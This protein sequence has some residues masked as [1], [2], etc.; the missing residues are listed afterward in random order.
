MQSE[1]EYRDPAPPRRRKKRPPEEDLLDRCKR[2]E[3]MLR[4]YGAN[5]DS[6][7]VGDDESQVRRPSQSG[8][9]G[10]GRNDQDDESNHESNQA[11]ERSE[12]PKGRI[13]VSQGKSRYVESHLWNTF[14][15]A[16]RNP[17]EILVDSASSDDEEDD[18]PQQK[19]IELERIN[20]EDLFFGI[21]PKIRDMS[22]LHPDPPTIRRLWTLFIE[23]VNSIIKVVH[24]PSTEALIF[25]AIDDPRSISKSL[26]VL[27]FAIYG[28]AVCSLDKEQCKRIFG[29]DRQRYLAKWL[30]AGRLALTNSRFLRTSDFMVLQGFVLYLV[31]PLS[32]SERFG[33]ALF[34]LRKRRFLYLSFTSIAVQFLCS[35]SFPVPL[36]C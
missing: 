6:P 21:A 23:N 30:G 12:F 8:L 34:T 2:Y 33:S 32:F 24:V 26:E 11:T 36:M 25:E 22:A 9:S 18:E 28:C 4:S 14:S 15:E 13:V 3:D 27:L 35:S 20:E 7:L 29:Q 17:S 16:F 19:L 5:I 31:R 10:S 1:C